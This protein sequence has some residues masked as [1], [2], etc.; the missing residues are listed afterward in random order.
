MKIRIEIK[1][2]SV[3]KAWTG[4]KFMSPEYKIWREK[5]GYMCKNYKKPNIQLGA[6]ITISLNVYIK[7]YAQSDVDNFAKG[8]LDG[9]QEMGMIENDKKVKKIII[10]KHKVSRFEKEFI[11]IDIREWKD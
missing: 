3:N 9:L 5:F 11:D 4:R 1:A 7:T 6:M 2:I 10:E 8:I